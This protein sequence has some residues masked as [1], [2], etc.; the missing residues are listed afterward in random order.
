MPVTRGKR[1]ETVVIAHRGACGYLPEHTLAAKALA[2]GLGADYLE[3]DVVATRDDQLLVMHD[4][5]VDTVTDVALRFPNRAREDGRFYARDFDLAE[6]RTLNVHERRIADGVTAAFPNRF[7]T[8]TGRFSVAS[9]D[10]ELSMIS[11]LNHATGRNTGIYPEVKSPAWHRAEGVDVSRLLLKMLSD[12]G[13]SSREDPVYVQC[14]DARETRRLREE[15]GS[16]LKLI[17]LIGDNSWN[18]SDT[19]YAALLKEDGM[20]QIAEFADGIGPWLDQLYTTAEIDGH[21]VSTG[22][23]SAAH[24]AGLQ[25]HPYTFRS[26]ALATGF[27][28]FDE[29]VCWFVGTLKVDGLFSDFPDK[30]RTAL[31]LLK[32]TA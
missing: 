16:D 9:L 30:A 8:N 13:Y 21:P 31:E 29:Q 23:V 14:F 19:D 28:S 26:D 12:Y 18:E 6:L 20:R 4:I 22:V 5:H 15:L 32:V 25:V 2:Y 27:G 17:Q 10:D 3:Q 11:G 7:P 24:N 1:Q